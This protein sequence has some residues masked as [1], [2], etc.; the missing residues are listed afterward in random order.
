MR[1]FIVGTV[2]PLSLVLASCHSDPTESLRNGVAEVVATPSQIFVTQGAT[3]KVVVT[4][5]DEQGNPLSQAYEITDPGSGITVVRDETY[6]PVYG[7]DGVLRVPPEAPEFRYNVTADQLVGTHFT[8]SAGD[9]HVDIP[10][11]V[12]PDPLTA[13]TNATVAAAGPSAQDTITL[14]LPSP[15]QFQGG[16]IVAYDVGNAVTVGRSADG[17]SLQVLALP[18]STGPGTISGIAINYAPALPLTIP[19]TTDP[20]TVDATITPIAGTD[21]PATAPAITIPAAGEQS[22]FIDAGLMAAA[23]CGQNSG[24]P[25]QL[26]KF[27]LAE[28]TNLH[29]RLQGSNAADLGLYFINAADGTDSDQLCD[30]LGRDEVP[31]ECD[32]TFPAGDY[33]MA[34]VSFGPFYPENDPNPD[35]VA[36]QL[37][38]D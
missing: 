22:G 3:A 38:H 37:R 16:A 21:A 4:S 27:S 2:I 14:T 12:K 7:A 26:Y 9:K 24:V 29:V 20:V 35:W 11:V 36:V 10:V 30:G 19:A 23:D 18:G 17:S 32:L 5:Y 8:V 6:L 33:L 13:S 1:R 28:E 34:V 31:E 25:C 15:Y